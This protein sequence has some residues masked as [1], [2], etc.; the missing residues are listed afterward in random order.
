MRSSQHAQVNSGAN[1]AALTEAWGGGPSALYW[2]LYASVIWRTRRTALHVPTMHQYAPRL[3]ASNPV[4][5]PPCLRTGLASVPPCAFV[6]VPTAVLPL[7]FPLSP[8]PPSLPS[9][10]SPLCPDLQY[11]VAIFAVHPFPFR[12]RLVRLPQRKAL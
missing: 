7:H 9:L 12:K 3:D 2:L 5:S 11:G 10:P 4:H 8:F 1:V 6:R